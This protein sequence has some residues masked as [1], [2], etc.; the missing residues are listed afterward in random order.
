[1]NASTLLR[2][3][4][5]EVSIGFILLASGVATLVFGWPD[6]DVARWAMGAGCLLQG[7][8]LMRWPLRGFRRGSWAVLAQ[9]RPA[10][11]WTFAAGQALIGFGLLAWWVTQLA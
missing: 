2:P 9:Q 1:M 4:P 5:A 11:L 8:A 3:S 7:V 10:V 6:R